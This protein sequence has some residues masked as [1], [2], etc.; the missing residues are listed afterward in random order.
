MRV[1]SLSILFLI[2]VAAISSCNKDE[3]TVVSTATG[4]N[5]CDKHIVDLNVD[6]LFSDPPPQP[7]QSDMEIEVCAC[8]TLV[9][10]PVNIPSQYEFE[11]WRIDQGGKEIQHDELV[12]DSITVS[13][14]LTLK[15]DHG[16]G[17]P[18]LR[19][20]VFFAPCE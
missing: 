4:T 6:S 11:H 2:G 10:R 19:I 5:T 15:F 20:D 17:H 9:L 14:A 18:N 16:P 12:L 7:W 3:L 1:R 13:S 8:D